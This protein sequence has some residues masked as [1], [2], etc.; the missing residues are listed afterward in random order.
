MQD[1]LPVPYDSKKLNS[2][3]MKYPTIDRELLCVV[4]TLKGFQFL[5]LG[6]EI[7]IY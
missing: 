6:A 5:L 7:H 1:N 3:E 4:A 2:V